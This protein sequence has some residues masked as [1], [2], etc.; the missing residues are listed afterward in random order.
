MREERIGKEMSIELQ[1]GPEK[2]E[3]VLKRYHF[4]AEV[5]PA[6]EALEKAVRP[7]LQV[8]AYYCWDPGEIVT[9]SGSMAAVLLTLGEGFDALQDLYLE[10]QCVSEGY[11]LDCIG[12]ELLMAAYEECVRRL[13]QE[14]GVYAVRLEFLGDR[15]PLELLKELV[16]RT[17][18]KGIT[19]ND[20]YVMTPR[21][22]VAFLVPME[23]QG[24]DREERGQQGEGGNEEAQ[25]ALCRANLRQSGGST[26][27]RLRQSGSSAQKDLQQVHALHI[28]ANCTNHTCEM[29]QEIPATYGY[30]RIFGGK[31][32]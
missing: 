27:N 24:A 22:T 8:R 7:L 4:E 30:Q 18:A 31:K 3:Q 12:M 23:K 19:Y 5:R 6:L 21:K 2:L 13:Q 9:S 16:P 17:G 29:R 15:Y 25:S 11:M 14:C 1:L 26:Q 28:C 32:S 10:R 20:Q